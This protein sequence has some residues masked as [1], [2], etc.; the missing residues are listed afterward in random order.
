MLHYCCLSLT[1]YTQNF[2]AQMTTK[3]VRTSREV[4][5][6]ALLYKGV[7]IVKIARL[8]CGGVA[9]LTIHL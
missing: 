2:F 6:T 5:A 7:K 4:P 1:A 9:T 8:S 3:A